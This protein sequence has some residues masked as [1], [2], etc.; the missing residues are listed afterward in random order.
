MTP[1]RN[2][3]DHYI[4]RKITLRRKFLGLSREEFA[5]LIQLDLRQLE[6]YEADFD[7]PNPDNLL[8]IAQGLRVEEDYF[9]ISS[10][11]T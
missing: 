9:L 2:N 10:A 5:M 4:G 7:Y 6:I 3:I 1:K 8:K 11:L